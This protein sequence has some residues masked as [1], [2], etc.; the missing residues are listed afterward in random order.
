MTTASAIPAPV[1]LTAE[2]QDWLASNLVRG[3]GNAELLASMKSN[4]FDEQYARIAI[5]VVR[6]MTERVQQTAPALLSEYEA[7]AMRLPNVNRVRAADREVTIAFT[8]INPNVA[9]INNLMS[10]DECQILIRMAQ[11]KLKRSEVV[12]PRTGASEVSGA[13]TSEGAHFERGEGAVVQRLEAR[14]EALTGVPV[15]NGEPLQMLHY[16]I[17]GEYKPHHDYFDPKEPGTAVLT[18][19]GGQ[20]LATMIIYLNDV[21]AGGETVFPELELAVKA[22]RGSAVYFE[23]QNQ[24]GELDL[25]CLHGGAPVARGEKWIV[26]KWL[27]QGMYVAP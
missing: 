18:K 3:V 22:V 11:G 24:K 15:I 25:R 26:T 12:A 13:R 6:A 20:R 21:E 8:L 2:W 16:S 19:A 17:G 23:Y 14:I 9:L 1:G 4:G 27:R 10:E 5:S 7:D